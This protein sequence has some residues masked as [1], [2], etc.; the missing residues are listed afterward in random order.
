MDGGAVRN[1][2][3][4]ITEDGRTVERDGGE[5]VAEVG[6]GGG[7]ADGLARFQRGAE[8]RGEDTTADT[9]G[10]HLLELQ[11]GLILLWREGNGHRNY[12]RSQYH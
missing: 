7:D 10:V 12:R 5:V 6:V 9:T 3:A 4:G 11:E 1:A 8:D 2:R